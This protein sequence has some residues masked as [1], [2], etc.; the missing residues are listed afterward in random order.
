MNIRTHGSYVVCHV[1][2]GSCSESSDRQAAACNFLSSLVAFI[3]FTV[4]RYFFP[5]VYC[6]KEL[7]D[8]QAP[9]AP[10]ARQA[11]R[12]GFPVSH[13][14]T[15]LVGLDSVRLDEWTLVQTEVADRW[16]SWSRPESSKVL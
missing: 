4:A 5:A 1:V 10:R 6:K 7:T 14:S 9:F 13:R 2:V 12:R 11:A 8:T 16:Q 3:L 15:L